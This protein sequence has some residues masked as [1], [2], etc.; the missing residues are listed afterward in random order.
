MGQSTNGVMIYGYDFGDPSSLLLA[1]AATSETNPYGYLKTSWHDDEHD[2]VVDEDGTELGVIALMTKRLY[3]AIPDA[4]PA[5]SD[6]ERE[7]VVKERLGV[8]FESYCSG[9]YPMYVLATAEFTVYRGDAKVVDVARLA[10]DPA[11]K[12]WDAKLAEALRILD[13]HPT[14]ERPAWLLASY[15]G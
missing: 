3:E 14:Q 1:E 4:K 12:G 2:E 7:E 15:W 5:E 8:W 11:A 9:D 13:V 10:D 6:W